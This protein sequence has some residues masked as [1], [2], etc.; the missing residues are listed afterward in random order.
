[1]QGG[2]YEQK[3]LSP[4]GI[5]IVVALHGAALAALMMAKM[6]PPNERGFE[7]T[8]VINIPLPE[9]PPPPPPPPQS[10]PQEVKQQHRSV[11]DHVDPIVELPRPPAPIEFT[12]LELP[13]IPYSPPGRTD[14][15][16]PPPPPTASGECA[17][18]APPGAR[19]LPAPRRAPPM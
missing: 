19:Q 10:N 11:I 3:R 7:T 15:L 1:M 2:F 8:K 6:D 4:T 14:I 5:V 18:R 13:E 17:G 16:P 9:T 12:R